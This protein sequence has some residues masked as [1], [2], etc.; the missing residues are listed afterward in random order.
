ML[1][2]VLFVKSKLEKDAAFKEG[3]YHLVTVYPHNTGNCRSSW[4]SGD[5]C[6]GRE[7][8]AGRNVMI[9][10]WAWTGKLPL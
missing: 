5:S 1:K 10:A 2:R 9:G 4:E 8:V 7:G 6:S 3:G